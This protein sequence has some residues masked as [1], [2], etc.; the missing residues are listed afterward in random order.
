MLEDA[1]LEDALLED[2]FCLFGAN[3]FLTDLVTLTGEPSVCPGWWQG[4]R[5]W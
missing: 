1:E 4:E 2:I 5:E 3:L